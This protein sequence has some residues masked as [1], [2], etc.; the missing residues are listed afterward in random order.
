MVWR[1]AFNLFAGISHIILGVVKHL[2]PVV[3]F[4]DDFM[5]ERV[6]L[7]GSH[8]RRHGFPASSFKLHLVRDISVT[9]QSGAQSRISCIGC[10]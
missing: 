10:P 9:S 4:I 2:R 7:H 1:S 3:P 5:G 6:T 8:S